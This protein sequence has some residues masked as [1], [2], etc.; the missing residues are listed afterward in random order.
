MSF[1]RS[2]DIGA[3]DRVTR[4]GGLILCAAEC[5]DGLPE[6]GA[7]ARALRAGTSHQQ[8]AEA[9]AKAPQRRPDDWQIQVHCRILARVQVGLASALSD[10]TVRS[11]HLEPV[12]DLDAACR[13]ALAEVRRTRG[14]DL[15]RLAVLPHGPITIP[16]V[17][18]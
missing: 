13:D 15:P 3:A 16:W 5:R 11:A 2:C 14:V 18:A 6:G 7:W 10:E 17:R 9:L 4:D 12:A 8:V 1:G